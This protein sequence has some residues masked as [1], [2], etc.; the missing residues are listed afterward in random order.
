MNTTTTN[1]FLEP[2]KNIRR[3]T[4]HEYIR[5]EKLQIV[6]IGISALY[7]LTLDVNRQVF[8]YDNVLAV[9]Y[10]CSTNNKHNNKEILISRF[11]R[12]SKTN[13]FL[14]NLEIFPKYW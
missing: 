4:K 9:N 10:S 6:W 5:R 2:Q 14:V 3:V 11:L 13:E 12:N 1:N 8:F 7:F